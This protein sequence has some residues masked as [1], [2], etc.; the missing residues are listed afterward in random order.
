MAKQMTFEQLQE[1]LSNLTLAQ[2]VTVARAQKVPVPPEVE[3]HV[4]ALTLFDEFVEGSDRDPNRVYLKSKPL[5]ITL[6]TEG[7]VASTARNLYLEV[8]AID[9]AIAVLTAA[10]KE[11]HQRGYNTSPAPA[12]KR[13]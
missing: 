9:A 12:A 7:K 2:V 5:P 13:A 8:R 1:T 10:R 4:A 11:A 6:D 3:S